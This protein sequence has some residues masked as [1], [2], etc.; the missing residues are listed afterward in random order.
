M[1]KQIATR[2]S[3]MI[4]NDREVPPFLK[5][6][7]DGIFLMADDFDRGITLII[8]GLQDESDYLGDMIDELGE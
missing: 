5:K 3:D 7:A 6:Q 4:T 8:D 2:Y 1:I